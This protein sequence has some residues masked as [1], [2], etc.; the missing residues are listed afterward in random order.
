M[1]TRWEQITELF[2]QAAQE[3]TANPSNWRALLIWLQGRRNHV[4]AK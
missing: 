4:K 2:K 3:V 1:A